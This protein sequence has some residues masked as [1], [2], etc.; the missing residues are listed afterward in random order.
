MQQA[1]SGTG[2]LIIRYVFVLCRL[3]IKS[4]LLGYDLDR[5]VSDSLVFAEVARL[6]NIPLFLPARIYC[7]DEIKLISAQRKNEVA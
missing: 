2:S 3:V 7:A 5:N 4:F 6:P 1:Y